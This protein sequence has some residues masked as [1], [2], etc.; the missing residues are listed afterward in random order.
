M[1]RWIITIDGIKA[2]VWLVKTIIEEKV[3]GWNSVASKDTLK[4]QK[5][6]K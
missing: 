2:K 6:Q 3:D 4:L 1:E 5:S